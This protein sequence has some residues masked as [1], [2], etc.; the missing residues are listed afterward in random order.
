MIDM[1][2]CANATM[3]GKLVCEEPKWTSKNDWS[4]I[5]FE[6]RDSGKKGRKINI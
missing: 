3:N 2:V 6:K 1:D 4:K 5:L